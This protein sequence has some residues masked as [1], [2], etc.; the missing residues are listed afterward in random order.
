MLGSFPHHEVHLAVRKERLDLAQKCRL[1]MHVYKFG[2]KTSVPYVFIGA[3]DIQG[4]HKSLLPIHKCVA[5]RL[6]KVPQGQLCIPHPPE[7]ILRRY[8]VEDVARKKVNILVT[9]RLRTFARYRSRL[10]GR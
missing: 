3:L 10:I 2:Q 7:A 8:S 4:H 5:S 9:I 6:D 1:H